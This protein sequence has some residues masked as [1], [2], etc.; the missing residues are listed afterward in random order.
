A[1]TFVVELTDPLGKVIFRA[2][3]DAGALV[4]DPSRGKFK[5]KDKDAKT[6]GGIAA[7]KVTHHDGGYRAT[8]K[9]DGD[10]DASQANMTTRVYLQDDLW[11]VVV[12]WVRTPK[13]WKFTEAVQ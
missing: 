10:L 4:G 13:G 9:M 2:S 1:R 11:T 6:L 5:Y 3:L 7:I 12:L 8:V